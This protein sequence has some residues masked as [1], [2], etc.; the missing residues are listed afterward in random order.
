M[1]LYSFLILLLSLGASQVIYAKSWSIEPVGRSSFGITFNNGHFSI[2][3]YDHGKKYYNNRYRN[4]RPYYRQRFNQRFNRGGFPMFFERRYNYGGKQY[5]KRFRHR[6]LNGNW[7][8]DP[9]H[10]F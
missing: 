6:H 1:I 4:N 5:N 9:R 7:C 2:G 3:Y 8:Y 10:L